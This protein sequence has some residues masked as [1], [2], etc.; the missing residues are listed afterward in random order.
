M[1]DESRG[2]G[3]D[4]PDD[5][6]IDRVPGGT[7]TLGIV[8]KSRL[9]PREKTTLRYLGRCFARLD[10]T[11]AYVEAP[12]AASEVKEGVEME[13]GSLLRL[14]RDVI[15]QADNTLVYPDKRL[16][17][18]LLTAYPD[19]F[20]MPNVQVIEPDRLDELV[21]AINKALARRD[22]PRPT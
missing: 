18:R 3:L 21:T 4:R 22:I 7:R 10:R 12:G 15:G 1:E 6:P 14:E 5:R 13:G 11:L 16:L 8:G 19:L 17:S 9:T 2:G 20:D